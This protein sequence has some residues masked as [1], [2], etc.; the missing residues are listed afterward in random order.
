MLFRAPAPGV[1]PTATIA[2]DIPSITPDWP[3]MPALT[4]EMAVCLQHV[5]FQ[6]LPS[7]NQAVSRP[8]A[9][10]RDHTPSPELC[11]ARASVASGLIQA[12]RGVCSDFGS[13]GPGA[14]PGLGGF[15]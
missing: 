12:S 9:L 11:R 6:A 8:V 1:A 4:A 5:S 13:W 7:I 14:G 3:P 10:G 15:R 2:T